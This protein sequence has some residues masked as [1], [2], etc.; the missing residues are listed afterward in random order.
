MRVNLL[1]SVSDVLPL[2]AMVQEVL[3]SDIVVGVNIDATIP[4]VF[5]VAVGTMVSVS[6]DAADD[7]DSD[8]LLSMIDGVGLGRT[9]CSRRDRDIVGKG[10]LITWFPI[11]SL[12]WHDWLRRGPYMTSL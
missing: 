7:I 11:L 1:E 3:L 12:D 4:S 6:I 2:L 8:V 10:G 9:R 5:G